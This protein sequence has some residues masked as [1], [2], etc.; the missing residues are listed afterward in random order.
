MQIIEITH[1]ILIPDGYEFDKYWY[2]NQGQEYINA[3]GVVLTAQKDFGASKF[4][5]IQKVEG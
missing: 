4:H 5:I 2:P 1:K 3:H